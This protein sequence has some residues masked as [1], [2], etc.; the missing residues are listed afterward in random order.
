MTQKAPDTNFLVPVRM[1]NQY[2]YCPRLAYLEWVQGEWADSADTVT[3]TRVHRRIDS[4]GRNRKKVDAS[5]GEADDFQSRSV[6]LSSERLAMI[7]RID[8][9]E[10]THDGREVRPVDYKKGKRPH[11]AKGAWE[12]ERV[13]L[14]AQ[15]MLL[16]EHGYRC[17][18]GIL[19]F[20]GSRER[21]RVPFDP[22]LKHRTLEVLAT[23]RTFRERTT[24]P[25]PLADNPKCVRCSL[26]PICLPE[27]TNLLSGSGK[28]PRKVTAK[29]RPGLPLHVQ[30]PGARIRK[31]G[32]VLEIWVDDEKKATA[33]LEEVS[34]LALYGPVQVTTPV[35]HELLRR[36]IGISYHSMG[37]WFLA[38][39]VGTGHSNVELRTAQY[40][41][42]FRSD[43]CLEIG[44]RLV[45]A[46][47]ANGR[48]L[49]RRNWRLDPK[50]T[51]PLANLAQR[52][53]SAAAASSLQTLLGIKGAAA[54]DYFRAFHGM[55]TDKVRSRFAFDFRGRHR[56]PPPDPVNSGSSQAC[57]R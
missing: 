38:P 49:I 45:A 33:R 30:E 8:V 55:L 11:V 37:G 31:Q 53:R 5:R 35:V 16:E 19:Y 10:E 56:R 39:L 3:G 46:K 25:A 36:Q 29:R 44:R 9:L 57:R 40:E 54:A 50:S 23:L 48:T 32:G 1:M 22:E 52:R 42:S 12:P 7:A 17:D 4:P 41:R 34:H 6:L 24:P 28:K 51:A 14:C 26:K 18:E 43:A 2:V 20:A 13:Q 47:I 21:V 15:G 27:E